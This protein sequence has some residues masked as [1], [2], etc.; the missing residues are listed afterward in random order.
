LGSWF[1]GLSPKSVRSLSLG[2][3]QTRTSWLQENVAE[4][5]GQDANG[6][7]VE[8]RERQSI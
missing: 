2:K 3:K 6:E 4:I 1:T 7:K 5:G 8:A